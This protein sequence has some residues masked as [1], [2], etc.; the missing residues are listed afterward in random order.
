MKFKRSASVQHYFL[1][2]L[3]HYFEIGD[4]NAIILL[5]DYEMIRVVGTDVWY[6]LLLMLRANSR[7]LTLQPVARYS[8]DIR[9]FIC[10][11]SEKVLVKLNLNQKQSVYSITIFVNEPQMHYINQKLIGN[12][13]IES[14]ILYMPP[15]IIQLKPTK[16]NLLKRSG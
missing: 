15:A 2:R 5:L 8:S 9:F 1:K 7:E 14:G 16:S 13:L 3:K 12:Q 11:S 10:L 6:Y 4:F